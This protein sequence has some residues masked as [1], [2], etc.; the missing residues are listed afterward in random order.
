MKAALT[1]FALALA[2]LSLGAGLAWNEPVGVVDHPNIQFNGSAA[3]APNGNIL[4]TWAESAGAEYSRCARL[5]DPQW[6]PLWQQP[7]SLKTAVP[8][9]SNLMAASDG[10]FIL[11]LWQSDGLYAYKISP[12]GSLMWGS[13]GVRVFDYY[14]SQV[15]ATA[16]SAGGAWFSLWEEQQDFTAIQHID[17]N[18]AYILPEG[19]LLLEPQGVLTYYSALLALPDNGVIVAYRL[20]SGLRMKRL[21]SGGETLWA[22]PSVAPAG[23]RDQRLCRFTEDSFALSWWDDQGLQLQRYEYDGDAVWSNPVCAVPGWGWPNEGYTRLVRGSDASV[24]LSAKLHDEPLRLQK[25]TAAG[26]ILFGTGIELL[27]GTFNLVSD[28]QGGCYAGNANGDIRL[29]HIGS[30][31][32]QLWGAEGIPVCVN[33]AEQSNLCLTFAAG[34]LRLLWMDWREGHTG[35]YGMRALA[36]G[37]LLDPENGQALRAGS[38]GEIVHPRVRALQ[39]SSVLVWLQRPKSSGRYQVRMQIVEADGSLLLRPEGLPLSGLC[40]DDNVPSAPVVV[41]TPAQQILVAWTDEIGGTCQTQLYSATGNPL[42]GT[43]SV[44]VSGIPYAYEA[45]FLEGGF[46]FFAAKQTTGGA[47]RPWGQRIVN[48]AAVWPAEGLLLVG[49]DPASPSFSVHSWAAR[50]EYLAWKRGQIWALRILADGSPAPGFNAWGNQISQTQSPYNLGSFSIRAVDDCLHCSWF[51]SY[52]LHPS[53]DYWS[54]HF[55][56]QVISPQG[57][58]MIPAPGIVYTEEGDP[59]AISDFGVDVGTGPETFISGYQLFDSYRLRGYSLTGELLSDRLYLI[60]QPSYQFDGALLLA[61]VG[62]GRILM[63]GDYYGGGQNMV[64]YAVIDPAAAETNPQAEAVF[65]EGSGKIRALDNFRE[66]EVFHLAGAM[67]GI[68]NGSANRLL[69][70]KIDV[71]GSP[72]PE[73]EE[74]TPRPF[75]L[76]APAPNPFRGGAAFIC[77]AER[78]MELELAVYNLRGQ[79]VKT[80]FKGPLD[81]GKTEFG[82]DGKDDSARAVAAGVYLLRASGGSFCQTRKLLKLD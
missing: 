60:N 14:N 54:Y 71:S 28:G 19:G 12:D 27:P 39:G 2:I 1:A 37:T 69:L 77:E 11:S 55:T 33:T 70:Q 25:V 62:E 36:A 45:T 79:K 53:F 64:G 61:G 40:V 68:A 15:E 82:W 23:A 30:A 31:G 47:W 24:F 35:V 10:S 46:I 26:Q 50:G 22:D 72:A 6:Q 9:Q 17:S 76:S 20:A 75:A 59:W 42:W 51:D 78:A 66:D 34:T 80:I 38:Y 29:A 58:A 73:E 67:S 5:Y 65:V 81:S 21:S 49:D 41:V 57:Q 63:L 16:D 43:G 32:E 3:S 74:M 13:A 8:T 52:L 4:V 18:G 44:A 56:Q 7:L 48:G